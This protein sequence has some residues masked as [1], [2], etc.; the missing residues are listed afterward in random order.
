MTARMGSPVTAA[1]PAP[2]PPGGETTAAMPAPMT[3]G[4]KIGSKVPSRART[5]EG[6][7][8]A[9]RERSGSAEPVIEAESPE[10]PRADD[11]RSS[12]ISQ[13]ELEAEHAPA[14]LGSNSASPAQASVHGSGSV[15][16]AVRRLRD[17]SHTDRE[18]V[19]AAPRLVGSATTPEAPPT[20]SR[21]RSSR[22]GSKRRS[23]QDA[24]SPDDSVT[25]EPL[26]DGEVSSWLAR[27]GLAVYQPRFAAHHVSADLLHE[28]DSE[29]LEKIGVHSWGHRCV[30]L[31][32]VAARRQDAAD[33]MQANQ[34]A[35]PP[36]DHDDSA[37]GGLRAV[38][39]RCVSVS[40]SLS[41]PHPPSLLFPYSFLPSFLP[42]SLRPSFR[43]RV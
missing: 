30:L 29:A 19:D 34:Q 14:T 25:V 5:R 28:L 18:T 41:P 2:L 38:R 35:A 8:V 23:G 39:K 24:A 3:R 21:D 20:S 9:P 33:A 22:E 32:S 27:L 43:V 16:K 40:C 1:V 31:R 17:T 13:A 10:R 6:A 12:T 42:L 36:P 7:V 37:L 4:P 11:K 15:P 26:V